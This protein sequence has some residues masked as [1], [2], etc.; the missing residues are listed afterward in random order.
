MARALVILDQVNTA[1]VAPQLRSR[2]VDLCQKLFVSIGLQTSVPK[3]HAI[4]EERGAVLD[5]LDYPL[6]NRWWLEDQF[7]QIAKVSSVDEQVRQLQSLARWAHPGEGSFYDDLGNIAN[8]PHV[9]PGDPDGALPVLTNAQEPTFWWWDE[10]KSRARLS[11]QVTEWPAR[12]VYM[13]LDPQAAYEVRCTGSGRALL[14]ING[15][16][17]EPTV[18]PQEM[19]GIKV[20]PVPA[21][22]VRNRKLILEWQAPQ[23]EEKLNWR[24]KSRLA[25]V[26]LIRLP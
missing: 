25:E 14:R 9:I 1:P 16:L 4:G 15:T 18:D 5:F 24:K 7:T 26:W 22:L 11:W 21:G 12:M 19:G 2:I 23:G 20:F 17:V 6:N 3:Y 10:G 8:S 13:G